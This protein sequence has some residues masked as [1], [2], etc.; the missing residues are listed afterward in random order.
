MKSNQ[1]ALSLNL[2]NISGI[3]VRV[4]VSFFLLLAWVAF[5]EF[6]AHG[7]PI[8]EVLF[9]IA[10]FACVLL[11]ELGHALVARRFQIQ[12]R[13]IVL[14]PFGGVAALMGEAKP[15]AELLIALAGPAVNVLIAFVLSFFID[16]SSSDAL[17]RDPGVLSRIFIAN[18]VLVVFNMIPALPMDGGRVLRATLALLK[19]RNATLISARL[20]QALSILMGLFALYTGN[21]ILVIIAVVVFMNA[22][23]EHVHDRAR[24]VA[25]G[26]TVQNVMMDAAHLVTFTHGQTISEA[27]SIG[28]K[29]LQPYFPVLLGDSILGIV[30]R[31]T[32]VEAA[33]S[34]EEGY[35]SAL[36]ER[37]FQ[38][39]PAE[40]SLENL[41]I[42]FEL[43][44]DIPLVVVRD[45][46]FA[47][48][49]TRDKMLEFLIV[50]GLRR[51]RDRLSQAPSESEF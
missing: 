51:E 28:I 25:T 35:V 19:V 43:Q 23:Q 27:L 41:L 20:S 42:Q 47:G 31:E 12:T 33:T 46:K 36:M 22:V 34:E 24:S 13:D 6:Q 17:L 38:T 18:V 26:F 16:L 29:S 3:P 21:P 44:G 49:L 10:V 1:S 39:I 14:Y 50:H 15:F 45:G 48:L 4:H 5:E 40:E 11:H 37:E 8:Q 30:S 9:V 2:C 7:Q 32:L